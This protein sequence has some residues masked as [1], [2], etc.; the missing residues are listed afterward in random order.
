[1][2]HEVKRELG[3]ERAAEDPRRSLAED[4]PADMV[5]V[6]KANMLVE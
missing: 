6:D 5:P 4:I 3:R 1:V 2:R